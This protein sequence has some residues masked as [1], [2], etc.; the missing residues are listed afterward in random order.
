MSGKK[1]NN[2][3]KDKP[4]SKQ[5]GTASRRRTKGKGAFRIKRQTSRAKER[6]SSNQKSKTNVINDIVG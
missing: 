4:V 1:K 5:E 6:T 2:A 3:T